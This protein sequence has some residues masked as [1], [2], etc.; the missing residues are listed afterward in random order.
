MG[1]I[2]KSLFSGAGSSLLQQL[3]GQL[4]GLSKAERS[5][6]A[7]NA[8][9]AQK[10]RDFQAEM[11]ASNNAFNAEQAQINR[12]FQADQAATQYQRGVVDM[13]AAGLNPALAYGQGGAS[14]MQGATA[15]AGSSPAGAAASGS[16]KGVPMS[17][18][19]LMQMAQMKANIDKTEHEIG[20]IDA[21]SSLVNKDVDYRGLEIA[22]FEPLSNA[23]L[24]EYQSHLKNDEVQ[25]ALG[26]VGITEKE[27]N[28]ALL[29]RQAALAKIDE[30]TRSY[31]NQLEAQ[32]RVA[33]IG[34][35]YANTAEQRKKV[36]LYQAQIT[37]TLQRSI[38]ESCLA[39]LYSQQELES[40]ERSGLLRVTRENEEREGALKQYEVDH[41]GLTYWV[42]TMQ[43][44]VDLAMTPVNV[45]SNAF[46]RVAGGLSLSSLAGRSVS[47]PPKANSGLWLPNSFND[48]GYHYGN[49]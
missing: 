41:K 27:A 32:Y 8:D 17:L 26:Q 3:F 13:R 42:N 18:S 2:L 1:D 38:T 22:F 44:V 28:A 37:E 47:A 39:G 19:D 7:F 12:D 20:L 48:F 35:T 10:N 4:F 14:A 11:Q 46:S 36:E 25:R 24:A 45:G 43:K 15:A 16:G 29:T 21:Q 9:Q 49:R 33:Q 5:Q 34:L 30:Q 40:M 6:N 23:K 31:L